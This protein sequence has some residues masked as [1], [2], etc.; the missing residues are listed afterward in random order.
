M[1]L[2]WFGNVT[3][4]QACWDEI[5]KSVAAVSAQDKLVVCDLPEIGGCSMRPRKTDGW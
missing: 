2:M 3:S 1:V 5:L 4:V